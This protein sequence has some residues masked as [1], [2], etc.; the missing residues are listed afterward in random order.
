MEKLLIVNADDFGFSRG[1]N[2]GIIEC[3]RKGLVSSTT[4][5][6][7]S[8]WI[9]HAAEL[10]RVNPELGVGLHFVL[11]WGKPLTP[12]KS[13]V[14]A[15]GEF[16]KWLWEYAEQG[17]IDASDIRAELEA[18]FDRFVTLF[19]RMPTHIDS[20]HFVH[21]LP[22][23]YPTVEQFAAEKSLPIRLDRNDIQK[24]GLMVN[25]PDS[26]EYFDARF[27]GP[28]I[29]EAL[30]LQLLDESSARNNQSIEIMCHPAFI[31][32]ELQKSTYCEPRVKEVDILTSLSLKQEVERRGYRIVSF[33][34]INTSTTHEEQQ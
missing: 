8:P 2:Y 4:A 24:F 5:M 7:T 23:I 22:A 6:V 28:E 27:Y 34:A 14:N 3:H 9:T 10:S 12:M 1:Q 30:F 17:H 33:A 31:D 29:S 18:Q 19:K 26:T 25:T 15:R 16:G 21:M 20:H 32:S 11:T 13:L